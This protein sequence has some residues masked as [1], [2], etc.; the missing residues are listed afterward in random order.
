MM[1]TC[2]NRKKGTQPDHNRDTGVHKRRLTRVY[3]IEITGLF[4]T[5]VVL[6]LE[7][8]LRIKVFFQKRARSQ[9]ERLS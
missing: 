1:F 4:M 3:V 8:V 2:R 6:K 5:A 9:Q 7:V